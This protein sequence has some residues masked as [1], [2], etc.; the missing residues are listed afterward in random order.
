MNQCTNTLGRTKNEHR[1]QPAYGIAISPMLSVTY[2]QQGTVNEQEHR[3]ASD[4]MNSHCC[5]WR[6]VKSINYEGKKI[7]DVRY[8]GGHVKW[9]SMQY[10]GAFLRHS[11][12][13]DLTLP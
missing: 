4:H 11:N 9:D 10:T 7:G 2:L 8:V 6:V 13:S 1:F 5:F 3:S 12:S